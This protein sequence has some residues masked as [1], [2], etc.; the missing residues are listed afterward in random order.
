MFTDYCGENVR[1]RKVAGRGKLGDMNFGADFNYTSEEGL[2]SEF[3]ELKK[4]IGE[5]V[6]LSGGGGWDFHFGVLKSVEMVDVE[7]DGSVRKAIRVTLDHLTPSMAGRR[8]F[9]PY[10]DSWQISVLE[11]D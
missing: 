8:E 5:V 2:R 1:V 4:H 9:S 6:V 11:K 7:V 3:E 10:I